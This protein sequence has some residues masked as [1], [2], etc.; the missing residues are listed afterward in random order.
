MPDGTKDLQNGTLD[1]TLL[2]PANSKAKRYGA[3]SGS[4]MFRR[5]NI[6]RRRMFVRC[7][8]HCDCLSFMSRH[9]HNLSPM[10]IRHDGKWPKW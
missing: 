4:K 2:A 1:G 6:V 3:A 8:G 5:R 7:N 10:L 9:W